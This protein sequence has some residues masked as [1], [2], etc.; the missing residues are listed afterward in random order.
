MI[1]VPEAKIDE[2]EHDVHYFRQTL[3]AEMTRLEEQCKIWSDKINDSVPID[4][5]GEI[6]SAVGKA[7][8]G[9]AK[10]GRFHQFKGLI[11]DCE[12]ESGQLKTKLVDL[13]VSFN[14]LRVKFL[15]VLSF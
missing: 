4:V 2:P 11:D 6:K 10:K 14:T 3:E 12:F 15:S 5:V 7:R 9:M 8:L 13:H 1:A